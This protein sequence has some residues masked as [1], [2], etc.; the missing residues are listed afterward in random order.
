MSE[1]LVA[2]QSVTVDRA[3]LDVSI[4]QPAD[5][6]F[7][8]VDVRHPVGPTATRTAL[9]SDDNFLCHLIR[10]AVAGEGSASESL[11]RLGNRQFSPPIW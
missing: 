11:A 9:N 8:P 2:S 6:Q 5:E 3:L 7:W 10:S 4:S 1:R